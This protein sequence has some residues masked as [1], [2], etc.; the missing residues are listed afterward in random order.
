MARY[1][2]HPIKLFLLALAAVICA[3]LA[4]AA[5]GLPFRSS[6]ETGGFGEWQ[7]G[8]DATLVVTNEQASDGTHSARATM[9]LGTTSDNY[10]EYRFGNHPTVGGQPL[11]EASELWL[12]F[13]SKFDTGFRW[14]AQSNLH[15]MVI[16]N[17]EDENSRR[18]YQLLINVVASNQVY[19]LEHLKWN[20]DRSFNRAI[21]GLDQNRNG[22]PATVRV[23]QWDS[24][25]LYVKLNT[26]GQANGIVRLWINGV[27]KVENTAVPLR[28]DSSF[29]PN[30]LILSNY[31]VDSTVDGRQRWDKF[32]LGETEPADQSTV[33]PRPPTLN[34]VR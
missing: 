8:L 9:T 13:D 20:A 24:F 17:F 6:F 31:A 27:L 10:K 12:T 7:G 4:G 16:L 28:E 32:F 34:E 30:K 29:T 5:T 21:N 23:G 33:R 15:K 26:P 11:T 18:R 14:P 2:S 1:V 22:A 25:K 19:F 3:P